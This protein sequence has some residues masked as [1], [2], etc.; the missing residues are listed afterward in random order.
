LNAA[1]IVNGTGKTLDGG[2][3]TVYDAGAYA[4]EALVETI[5]A[6][7]KRFI[8]YGVDL[9][10][11]IAVKP[12]AS[13]RTERQ[14]SAHRGVFVSKTAQIDKTIYTI[15]NVDA[16]AKTLLIERPIRPNYQ[17]IDT[18]K[19]IETTNDVYRFEVKLAPNAQVEFPVTEENVFDSS[20]TISSYT[21]DTLRFFIQN[22]ALSDNARKQIQ[23]VVDLK[24]KLAALDSESS[25]LNNE[26]TTATREEERL[27]Q[28]IESLSKVSGQQQV[29]QQYAAKLSAS[30]TL[31]GTK[32]DRIAQIGVERAALQ[33]DLDNRI[34]A[35]EF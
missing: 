5:K 13:S 30:E 32:T 7:D 35:L 20:T 29:V 12:G 34:A 18:A 24:T 14:F 25:R 11:R 1:E 31:I 19:P 15:K 17:L 3:I 26:V 27:R 9:G 21:P 8:S 4:G 10:T 16:K 6:N 23:G 2:P 28:N 33:A 22:K